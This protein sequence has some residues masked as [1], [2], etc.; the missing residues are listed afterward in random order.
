ML[1]NSWVAE[2]LAAAP[3]RIC[4]IH[5]ARNNS[6]VANIIVAYDKVAIF[7]NAKTITIK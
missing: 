6:S 3:D 7:Y 5:L 2:Q 1:G 4:S